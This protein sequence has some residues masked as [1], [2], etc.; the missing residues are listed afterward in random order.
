MMIQKNIYEDG[1]FMK[2]TKNRIQPFLMLL[3]L[4]FLLSAGIYL[5]RCLTFDGGPL[6]I[7][8]AMG[9]LKDGKYSNSL[10]AFETNY[11]KGVRVFE[12]D[13][14]VT[15]DNVL[16]L[17]HDWTKKRGQEGL[18]K[19][20]GYIP[21]Y[22]EFMNTPL[23]G[24][25]TPLSCKDIFRLMLEYDDIYIV[26]DTKDEDYETVE[27]DFQ[28]IVQDAEEM[29]A[30]SC[31]DRFIVQIYNDE[32]YDAVN[33][34]HPFQNWIYTV[35]KRGTDN[36]E[37]LCQF[38]VERNIQVITMNQKKYTQEFQSMVDQYELQL[39]LHT[40]NDRKDAREFY[41]KGVDGFYTDQLTSAS[42]R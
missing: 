1:G 38:C 8:H 18:L 6:I 22:E 36:F 16:I 13:F 12:A 41:K 7:G 30:T 3:L 17:R 34:V 9:G 28:L 11:K 4:L 33:S 39:Y 14:S 37:Q 20:E 31:L 29:N 32:M 2:K 10:E 23:Y 19:Y 5:Y 26:T 40:V 27:R 21:T 15:S 24:K 25:Y 42:F 35:Y